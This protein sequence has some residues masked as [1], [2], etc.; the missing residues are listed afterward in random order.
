MESKSPPRSFADR[1]DFSYFLLLN[2]HWWILQ[3][4]M[5]TVL[6]TAHFQLENR[7]LVDFPIGCE[8][9]LRSGFWNAIWNS[10]PSSVLEPRLFQR[11]SSSILDIQSMLGRWGTMFFALSRRMKSALFL[12]AFEFSQSYLIFCTGDAHVCS[13]MFEFSKILLPLRLHFE[14]LSIVIIILIP[15]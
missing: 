15:F 14:S 11:L 4:E 5:A 10:A 12:Y 3:L 6:L 8:K 9:A 2:D 13:R 7:S 1:A